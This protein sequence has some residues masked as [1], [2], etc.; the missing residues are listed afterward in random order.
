[1]NSSS[2]FYVIILLVCSIIPKTSNAQDSTAHNRGFS[3]VPYVGIG[4]MEPNLK[5]GYFYK[6]E[7]A[8]LV[9]LPVA[10]GLKANYM[11][12]KGIGVRL[13]FN[14]IHKGVGYNEYYPISVPQTGVKVYHKRT[15]TKIRANL[16]FD[17]F[18]VNSA[19]NQAYVSFNAGVKYLD[20]AY[21][22]DGEPSLF[23]F[24]YP[25]F[26]G[27]SEQRFPVPSF[28]LGFGFNHN[29]SSKLFLST[30]IGI[31]SNPLH[32]GLGVRL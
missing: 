24:E 32:I 9:G 28:R 16:G 23:F 2:I 20:E 8:K 5:I 12:G 3:I 18:Y 7:D 1:M 27:I 13:D 10:F 4:V 26:T 30:E 19:T 17:Y 6:R 31:G 15:V 21:T 14:F 11:T 25:N 22:I 29:F